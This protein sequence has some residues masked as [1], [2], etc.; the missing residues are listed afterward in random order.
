L[1]WLAGQH[2][3]GMVVGDHDQSIYAFRGADVRNIMEFE[4]DFPNTKVIP[5]EQNYR[6]TNTILQAANN[7]ISNN[8]ERKEKNRWSDLGEGEPVRVI[9]TEDE[10]GEAR[11]VAAEIAA[12]IEE[13]YSSREIAVVYRSLRSVGALLQRVFEE[14]GLPIALQ[15]EVPFGHTPLGR[16]LIALARCAWLGDAG[17]SAADLITYLRTPGLLSEPEIADRLALTVQLGDRADR[18]RARQ[19]YGR[20]CCRQ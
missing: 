5:L 11:F 10:H 14:F 18:D 2:Q 12:R 16:G 7:V 1:Q 13:G 6:S 15:R 20:L 19:S 9:E 17:A 8:R 3:S 4:R